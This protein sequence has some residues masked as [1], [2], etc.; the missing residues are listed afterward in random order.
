MF[1]AEQEGHIAAYAIKIARMFYGLPVVEFLK[2]IYS[3]AIAVGSKAIPKAWE[4]KQEATRDWYYGFMKRHPTL[5]LKNPEG[6]SIARMVAFNR[7]NVN[8]FFDIFCQAMD[9]YEFTPDRIFNLDESSLTTVMKP[10][11][12]ICEKG[13]PVAS[14]ISRERGSSMTFVGII[15]AAGSFIPPVFVIPRK[16]VDERFMSETIDGSKG[17]YHSNGWM[18]GEIF[19]ETL[20]HIQRKTYCSVD[21]KICLIMD[22]AECHMNIHAVEY[23][24]ENGIVIVTLPPHTTAKLQPLDVGVFGPFKTHMRAE[25]DSF[26]RRN[27]NKPI[28]EHM[29]PQLASKAWIKACTP[30]NVL[31]AFRAT[32]IWPTN[33]D[34]F[35]D[36]AF[37]GAEV[38][39]LPAP[40]M[41]VEVDP[42]N[43]PLLQ[44][45]SQD[46]MP[47]TS[48]SA[49]SLTGPSDPGSSGPSDI[50]P[51][52]PSDALAA[53]PTPDS[54][55]SP[56]SSPSDL[57]PLGPSDHPIS[58]NT[59]YTRSKPTTPGTSSSTSGPPSIPS[60]PASS[61]QT[62]RPITPE[63][64]RPFPKAPA[65]P[66][67][68]GRKRVKACILTENEEALA[69]L[70]AKEAKK[71]KTLEKK[72]KAAKKTQPPPKPL[73][74]Q[75]SD[76][77]LV[78]ERDIVYD[79]SSDYSDDMLEEPLYTAASY[80]FLDKEPEVSS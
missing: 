50:P 57:A 33:R 26:H 73:V 41:V 45:L 24:I 2:L 31:S 6:I 7:P 10:V 56:P 51:L 49:D 32:G 1:T 69:D 72:G 80:P 65:R 59:F 15:S 60:T 14:Q 8:L 13:K 79:D 66:L 74:E 42:A 68:K 38:S 62:S 63:D 12:V 52:S 61:I 70:R 75:E 22:N 47:S 29:L 46:P 20:Q 5:S 58:P 55:P 36:E 28:T 37:A 23:A 34:I 11:R 71:A 17:I 39:D 18:N 9:K 19:L 35:P 43:I 77:E 64:I 40:E 53:S 16:R 21:N 67:G 44:D 48:S 78:D 27:P 3:Y 30:S 54:P 25:E 4:N 76:E